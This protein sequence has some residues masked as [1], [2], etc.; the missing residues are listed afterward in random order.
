MG[1]G[2]D[3]GGFSGFGKSVFMPING[4][5]GFNFLD[6]RPVIDLFATVGALVKLQR[7]NHV[8]LAFVAADDVFCHPF[9]LVAS[10]G[11]TSFDLKLSVHRY[12]EC[13]E[14]GEFNE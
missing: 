13:R 12:I 4:R 9:N 7:W 6:G 8:W 10:A 2:D 3:N 5:N 11:R 1:W 14:W